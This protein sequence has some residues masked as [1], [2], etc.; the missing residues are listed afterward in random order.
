[1]VKI[2]GVFWTKIRNRC[3]NLCCIVWRTIHHWECFDSILCLM[4]SRALGFVW[5]GSLARCHMPGNTCVSRG[6]L[7]LVRD[8]CRDFGC[9]CC[10]PAMSICSHELPR[11]NGVGSVI[12]HYKKAHVIP[13]FSF[14]LEVLASPTRLHYSALVITSCVL[15]S[16]ACMVWKYNNSRRK[17]HRGNFFK[18]EN[19]TCI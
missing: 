3:M 17:I 6:V 9:L 19:K 5:F 12:F 4:P 15:N 18:R 8:C 2:C 11:S 16:S 1:M 13:S 14:T 10:I 7:L